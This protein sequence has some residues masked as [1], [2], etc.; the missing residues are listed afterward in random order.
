MTI[1]P[2]RSLAGALA[3]GLAACSQPDSAPREVDFGNAAPLDWVALDA[4]CF[5][6]GEDRGYAEEGPEVEACVDSFSITR[7]EITN[8]QFAA[9]VEATGYVTA[10]EA[11]EQPGSAIFDPV[12]GVA[13]NLNWWRF[14]TGANW[15]LPDG[16]D[17]LAAHPDAPVIHVTQADAAAFAAWAGGRLPTEAEWEYAARGGLEGSLYSWAEAESAALASKANTWQG[18]FP[19]LDI[20]D[21]GHGGLAPVGQYPPNGFGLH[22]MI[23]NVWEWTTSPYYG[24]HQPGDA[25]ATYPDG[26]DPAQPGRAV[27][28]IKGGSFLC[29]RSYCYRF[30]PAARQAQDLELSTSHIGFR[31]VADRR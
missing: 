6:L 5:N 18:V 14:E 16:P 12:E 4:A 17:G 10:A 29:A 3:L 24:S 26:R 7:F 25:L 23:G 21:D 13:E 22:D 27:G 11:S 28:V 8:A 2:D 19:V 20:A 9:F 1:S 31:V 15:R 30:R